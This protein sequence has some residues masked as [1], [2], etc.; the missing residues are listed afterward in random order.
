M[1]LAIV[2]IFRVIVF[3]II[4]CGILQPI[5]A[6]LFAVI[7]CPIS[8]L[9]VILFTLLRRGLRFSRDTFM[10][11]TI[12]KP[13]ARVPSRDTFV[14]KRIAGPGLA[15]NYFYQVKIDS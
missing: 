5:C 9:F 7:V 15:S 6:F 4:I 14:A 13:K 1:C 3:N 11:Y 10:F 2:P 12:L 8:S